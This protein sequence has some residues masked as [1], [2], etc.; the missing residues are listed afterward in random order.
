MSTARQIAVIIL[1]KVQ[2]GRH[3]LDY[4]LDQAEPQIQQLNR[5]D[6]ALLRAMV[7]GVLRWQGR[8]DW[9][10]DDLASRPGKI[11]ALIRII[12]RLGLFQIH[13]LERI[14]DSAA[15]NTSVA[16]A[17]KNG[18]KWSAGFVNGLL[19]SAIRGADQVPWPSLAKNPVT[20]IAAIHSFPS[21]LISRWIKRWGLDQTESLCRA[22]NTIPAL[23]L[24]TNILKVTRQELINAAQGEADSVG[25]TSH[26][27]QG[28]RLRSPSRPLI[29]WPI[30]EKGWFQVQD[31][32]AQLI[33]HILAPQPGQ[34]VWD[35]CAGLGTKTAHLAQLMENKGNI[36][37][38]DSQAGKLKQLRSEMQRLGINIVKESCLELGRPKA[39]NNI[40]LFDRI[41]VDAPCSGLGVLQKNPD[42]K[43]RTQLKDLASNGQRQLCM[44]EHAAAHLK[45]NG[46]LVYSVCSFEPEENRQVVNGFL[47]KHP[48]FVI[49]RPD[50]ESVAKTDSLLTSEGFLQTLPHQQKMDGFFAA[51]FTRCPH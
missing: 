34:S 49:Y 11:D 19:R 8:L 16:L 15:V 14:P 1:N 6:K 47:Q 46:V 3:T 4:Y 7:Y 23:T 13:F 5:P 32:A 26:C 40:P 43:W 9:I 31:E 17:K 33:G 36:L 28:V 10:I 39:D 38:S 50:L 48:E 35:A 29:H 2:T 25:L 30:F 27:P 20:A 37:A 12:L 42:G 51:A 41:L 22:V 24:R 45:S 18:R 44:L 21:W